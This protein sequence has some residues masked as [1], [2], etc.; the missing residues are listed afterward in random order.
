M[1][2]SRDSAEIRVADLFPDRRAYDP[3]V[4][5]P[6][7]PREDAERAGVPF[8]AGAVTAEALQAAAAVIGLEAGPGFFPRR[9]RPR[10][11]SWPRGRRRGDRATGA[12]A[13]TDTAGR[14]RR[15]GGRPSAARDGWS[16]TWAAPGRPCRRG[17]P[18][19]SGD[20][21]AWRSGPPGRSAGRCGRSPG[22]AVCAG[23]RG[24]AGRTGHTAGTDGGGSRGAGARCAAE[25]GPPPG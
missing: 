24:N 8:S 18:V 3:L 20:S 7:K 13:P 22:H 19:G 11:G 4:V 5:A 17:S 15:P 2:V 25:G 6:A 12:H 1:R 16:D 14:P 21:E 10:S 23:P 9:P